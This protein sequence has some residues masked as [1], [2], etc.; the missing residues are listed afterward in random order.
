[1]I[2]YIFCILA[3]A[4]LL[5]GFNNISDKELQGFQ[6]GT[7]ISVND[8][9]NNK[10]KSC[11]LVL[12]VDFENISKDSHSLFADETSY[13]KA[14]DCIFD[15]I[16]FWRSIVPFKNLKCSANIVT[17]QILSFLNVLFPENRLSHTGLDVKYTKY[18]CK[19]YV[20]TLA[21]ILI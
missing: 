12:S 18:S 15:N 3:C 6:K 10:I 11:N 8:M 19:Y 14:A 21:H 9:Q 13:C 17:I 7:D 16:S 4:F 1:M 5:L 20:Y 2:K